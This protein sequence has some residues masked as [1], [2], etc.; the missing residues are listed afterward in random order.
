MLIL[1]TQVVK[2]SDVVGIIERMKTDKTDKPLEEVKMLN[3]ELKQSI[4][5]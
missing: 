5:G 1:V 2:G 4:D 3:I